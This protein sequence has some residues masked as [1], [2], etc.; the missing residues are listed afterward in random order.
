MPGLGSKSLFPTHDSTSSLSLCPG[1]VLTLS[2]SLA[3][4]GCR[5]SSHV[6]RPIIDRH[7]L[8]PFDFNS[9]QFR[10]NQGLNFTRLN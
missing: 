4:L 8:Q 5:P 6:P 2:H 9:F 10:I 3:K 1:R 7:V